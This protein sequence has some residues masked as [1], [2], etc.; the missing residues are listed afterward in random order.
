M[1]VVLSQLFQIFPL[2]V[3]ESVESSIYSPVFGYGALAVSQVRGCIVRR[4]WPLRLFF[5]SLCNIVLTE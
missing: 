2:C 5:W 3:S 1:S 4:T